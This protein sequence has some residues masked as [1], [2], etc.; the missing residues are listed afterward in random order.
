MPHKASM[1]DRELA[2]ALG[3]ALSEDVSKAAQ[4]IDTTVF[5]GN[6]GLSQEL[7]DVF[8]DLVVDESVLLS[9]IAVHRTNDPSGEFTKLDVTG[10][11][12]RS[13][14]ENTASTETRKP[15][16]I[17][18][19]FVTAKTQSI[20]DITG[21]VDEDNI[22]GPRGST[23]IVNAMLKQVSNDMEQLAIEGDTSVVGA[24]DTSALVQ[25]N[26]GYNVLTSLALGTHVKDAGDKRISWKLLQQMLKD[27]PTRYRRN[28][29]E[30]R[31]IMSSNTKLDLL[32]EVEERATPLGDTAYSSNMPP[33]SPLGI[34]ILEIPLLPEDLTLSG[35][36]S[37]GTFIM[38]T[39]LSNLI[40]VVQRDLKVHSE[41]VPRTDKTEFTTF[42]RTDFLVENT[43]AVVKATNVVIDDSAGRFGA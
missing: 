12:T 27:L 36:A 32:G 22:E 38:L 18:L 35:T 14:T 8:I 19:P 2:K 39:R 29:N 26:N 5:S 11:I 31:W 4:P 25:T 37:T 17:P 30:L 6:G 3:I 16:N 7:A 33:T 43:D 1:L 42:M 41:Y 13:A 24:D 21:E 40:Y 23:T 34:Q 15:T 28:L 10:P 9:N 20:F